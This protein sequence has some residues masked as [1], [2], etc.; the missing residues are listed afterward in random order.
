[1]GFATLIM[2]ECEWHDL[3]KTNVI[4][5]DFM[6]KH[7]YNTR[8]VMSE[9]QIINAIISDEIFGA[10]QCDISCPD[11]L[12]QYFSEMSP[13]FKSAV[14][15]ID[16]IGEHMQ[17][18]E[19]KGT[20]KRRTLV[21]GMKAKHILLA[22]P[23]LQF[24][25]AKGMTVSNIN[26]VVEYK[27]SRCFRSFTEDV[28]AARRTADKNPSTKILADTAKL[29]GNSGYGS[30][31]MR[32]DKF[33]SIKYCTEKAQ[34][35]KLFNTSEFKAFTQLDRNL[36]EVELNKKTI[37]YDM[38]IQ[39]G[40]F[41]LNYAKLRMLNFYYDFVDKFVGRSN[42]EYCQTDTDSAYFALT[43]ESLADSIKPSQKLA[44]NKMLNGHCNDIPFVPSIKNPHA[45]LTRTCCDTHQLID[46]RTPGLFKLEAVGC[47]MISLCSKCYCLKRATGDVK[48]SSKGVN[49]RQLNKNF[50]FDFFTRVL[51]TKQPEMVKNIGIKQWK[52]QMVTYDQMKKGFTY[53]Y[54]KRKVLPDGVS[55]VPLDIWL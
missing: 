5:K 16:D 53:S 29:I 2:Y 41:V 32:V 26:L 34:V 10:V 38:P 18:H 13:V 21:G 1:M 46:K 20:K 4:V 8:Y 49:Q 6:K 3:R 42:F 17:Q 36:F 14:I 43:G 24:Y 52:Q 35:S 33:S 15:K 31:L 28:T 9:E 47:A 25:I 19:S 37:R 23:L 55:T 22:T 7:F 30:L 27:P 11:D 51:F 39:V 50:L 48:F 44:F 40:F 54:W 45:Y 12:F